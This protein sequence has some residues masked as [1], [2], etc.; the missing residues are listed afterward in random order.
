MHHAGPT[1]HDYGNRE[2]TEGDLGVVLDYYYPG[3]YDDSDMSL[4]GLVVSVQWDKGNSS[5]INENLLDHEIPEVTPD[6]EAEAIQSIL[7]GAGHE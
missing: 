5:A 1:D 6:E 2:C 4:M 7:K 3:S